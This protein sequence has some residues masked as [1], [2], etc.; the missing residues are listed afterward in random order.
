METETKFKIIIGVGAVIVFISI[1]LT[2]WGLLLVGNEIEKNG[3]LGKSIG[4]FINS[5]KSEIK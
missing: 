2:I 3:G 1:F 5:V 4:R